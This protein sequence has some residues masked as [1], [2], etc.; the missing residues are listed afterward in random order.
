MSAVA[1]WQLLGVPDPESLVVVPGCQ[2]RQGDR[3]RGVAAEELPDCWALFR[4]SVNTYLKRKNLSRYHFSRTDNVVILLPQRLGT[5]AQSIS[6]T[7]KHFLFWTSSDV[8]VV[9]IHAPAPGVAR[10]HQ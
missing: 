9:P 10:E 4:V 3:A 6:I 1:V 8:H 5:W 2:R 7:A